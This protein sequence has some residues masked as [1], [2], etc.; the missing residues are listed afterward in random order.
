VFQGL[1]HNAYRVQ[2]LGYSTPFPILVCSVL[3]KNTPLQN[4]H[5]VTD[6]ESCLHMDCYFTEHGDRIVRTSVSHLRVLWFENPTE[7]ATALEDI[8]VVLISLSRRW[9][10]SKLLQHQ[11]MSQVPHTFLTCLN[12]NIQFT[13][14]YCTLS[15]EVLNNGSVQCVLGETACLCEGL[16]PTCCGR[17]RPCL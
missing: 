7:R 14:L 11:V 1:K 16:K 5:H 3:V 17:E 9:A 13:D 10:W 6:F 4:I 15:D 2:R 12:S 8:L